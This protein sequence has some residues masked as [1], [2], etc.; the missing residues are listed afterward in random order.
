[1]GAARIG[2]ID[3]ELI[4][5][6]TI[7]EMEESS[8]DLRIAG[9]KD[10]VLMVEAGADIV[11]EEIMLEALALGQESYQDMIRVQE[12]MAAAIGKEKLDLKVYGLDPAVVDAVK[13]AA[14]D[15]VAKTVGQP[16]KKAEMDAALSA[17][18]ADIAQSLAEEFSSGDIR[19]AYE[20]MVKAE[21]RART[22]SE[23]IRM[24][25]RTPTQIRPITCEV[26]LIPRTHGSGLFTRGETQVLDLATLGSVGD[27][28]RL[29]TLES[30]EK[31]R[32]I[33]HYNF[34]PF[35]TGEARPL[36]GPRRRDIGHGALAERALLPV[37]PKSDEFPYTIRLVSEV[38]SSN[39][40]SSM[41]STCASSLSLMDA[42]VPIKAAVGGIAMGLMSDGDNYVILS[43]I[44]GAEDH[45]GDMDF[46]VTGTAEGITAL[47]MDIKIAGLSQEIMREALEQAREGRLF[48]LGKMAEAIE[49]PREATSPFAPRITI[50]KINPEKIGTV[51]GPGGKMIRKIVEETGAQ[52]DIEDDGSVFISAPDGPSGL[53]AEEI[54][55]GLTEEPEVG[56]IYT[57]KVVRTAAFGAFVEF[58]PGQDGLVHISQ[59]ADYRVPSVEDV[60]QV[61]DEVMVMVIDIGPDGK[62]RLSRQAVLE[63]WTAEE[64]RARDR[65]PS[66]NR[67]RSRQ[68]RRNDRNRR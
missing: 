27:E 52:I 63:G 7:P 25:G 19:E 51:I 32:Y 55:R 6:P 28:L 8:L 4:V 41:A 58:M 11:P 22:L 56:K 61:G 39:G 65:K 60:V 54:V 48:I 34:P 36:R 62:V 30:Q 50:V 14:G 29:D 3:G 26:G 47:Q 40:S 18:R 12:E 67:D 68:P 33:H 17:I 20:K 38:L 66:G 59:L 49:A 31:Q 15:R 5:N 9:T 2:Y 10:A 37:V 1:V 45:M 16:L 35:S 13:A 44:Q 53:R 43:D 24:D 57:G 21:V 42:G 64:A 46:K 23:G